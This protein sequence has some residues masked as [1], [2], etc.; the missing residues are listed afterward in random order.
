MRNALHVA[1]C[2]YRFTT[3]SIRPFVCPSWFCP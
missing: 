3:L 1:L 2:W